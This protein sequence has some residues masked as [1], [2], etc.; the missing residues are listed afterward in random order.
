MEPPSRRVLKLRP[1]QRPGSRLRDR[2]NPGG[3]A[4]DLECAEPAAPMERASLEPI[5]KTQGLRSSASR[6]SRGSSST[7][8][9]PAGGAGSRP[10]CRGPELLHNPG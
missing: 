5:L 9:P 7:T 4:H 1:L 8:D 6:G 10:G 2:G 3:A